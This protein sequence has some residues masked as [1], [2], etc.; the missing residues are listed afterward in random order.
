MKK[1]VVIDKKKLDRIRQ[2]IK[3]EDYVEQAIKKLAYEIS[4]VFK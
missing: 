4:A 3:N 2:K 1:A